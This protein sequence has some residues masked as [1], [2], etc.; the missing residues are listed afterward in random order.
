MRSWIFTLALAGCGVQ[1]DAP[2]APDAAVDSPRP[3]DAA[4]GPDAR[5]CTGG[6]LSETAPDGSCLLL[7]TSVP[8]SWPDAQAACAALNA[9]LAIANTATAE[10][11]MKAFA[12]TNN[13]W[14]GLTDEPVENSWKWVDASVPFTFMAWDPNEPNNGSGMYE[15]DCVVIAGSRGGDWDDRPCSP[16]VLAGSGLFGYMCQF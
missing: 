9:H 5:P 8:T 16:A 13:V 11:A 10:T 7:F 3:I 14:I 2:G 15:E 4:P 1:V 12:G 6:E